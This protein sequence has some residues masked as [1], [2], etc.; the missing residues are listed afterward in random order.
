M[1]E[2]TLDDVLRYREPDPSVDLTG[3][4][5]FQ[6]HAANL[7]LVLT[8]VAQYA[9]VAV[10]ALLQARI[11]TER[12]QGHTPQAF[13]VDIMSFNADGYET[14]DALPFLLWDESRGLGTIVVCGEEGS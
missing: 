5:W 7:A 14:E 6:N 9:T 4:R 2:L 11:D 3:I 10:P 8:P 13:L 12:A 1:Y